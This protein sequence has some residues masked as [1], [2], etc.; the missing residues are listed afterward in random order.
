[1]AG[2]PSFDDI[3]TTTIENRSGKLADNATVSTAFLDRLR[4]RG[5]VRTATGGTVIL[6]ELE[7]ALNPNGGWYAGYDPLSTVP[8]EPFSAASYDW[9]QAY[10]PIVWSGLEKLKNMGEPEMIDL[11]AS[12]IRNGEKSLYDLVATGVFSDGTGS[13]GKQI[14]GLQQY[15]VATPTSGTVGGI[16][17]AGT[18]N[19]FWRNKTNSVAMSTPVNLI[20]TNPPDFIKIVNDIAIQCTRGNDRPDLWVADSTG[21]KRYLESLQPIQR[22]TSVEMAGAGFSALKYFGVGGDADFVLDN[23]HCPSKT[24]YALNTNYIYLRPHPERNFVAFGG[25]RVPVNQDATVRFLG[26]TGNL[27]V[28]CM[29]L[30]GQINSSN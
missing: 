30:Q 19:T 16:D 11:V 25:D 5:K 21:Y 13:G 3:V 27:T 23:G 12:R 22:I 8:F 6:Q 4:R 10:V 15:V 24:V 18:G 7:V 2:N 29:F 20:L 28:S 14:G 17:R 1:M 9:K 26:F